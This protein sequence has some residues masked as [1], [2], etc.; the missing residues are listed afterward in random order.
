M[1]NM[2]KLAQ[3][4]VSNFLVA[5]VH[6]SPFPVEFIDRQLSIYLEY[7]LPNKNIKKKCLNITEI[8]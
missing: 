8:C 4:L 7:N 5:P 3:M 6:S 1:W 2:Y